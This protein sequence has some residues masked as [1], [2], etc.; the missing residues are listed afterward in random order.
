[1][2]R[3]D[4]WDAVYQTKASDEVSWFESSP[5]ISLDL[6]NQVSPAPRSVIDVGGGHSLLVD[7]LLESD[8]ERIAVLDISPVALERSKQ[9]LGDRATRVEWIVADVTT[10][11]EVGTFELWHDRAVFHFLTEPQDRAA[12]VELAAKSILP[13]GHLITGTFALDG[14]EKCSGL[15]VCRYDADQLAK[16]LG[17]RFVLIHQQHHVHETPS[18]NPQSFFF[19][20]FRRV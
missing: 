6:I 11:S 2:T 7:R 5:K 3:Q 9:R 19:G 8:F 1:V 14:P 18:G 13:G 17:E 16:T 15:P 20:V 4:H 10:V 12:Y